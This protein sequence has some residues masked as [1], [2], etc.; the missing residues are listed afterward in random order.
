M[1]IK[2][3]LNNIFVI[4]LDKDIDRYYN[5]INQ[6]NKFT[7]SIT[8]IPAIY[9]KNLNNDLLNY[10]KKNLNSSSS[11]KNAVIG[12]ALSH[13]KTY[14]TIIN[15][16]LDYGFI[17]ED[18]VT[19][20]STFDNVL[21]TDLPDNWDILYIGHTKNEYPRNTCSRV[22]T[23]GYKNM[24]MYNKRWIIFDNEN[25]VPMGTWSYVVNKKA[26]MY[27]LNNYKLTE[28]IDVF[29]VKQQTLNDL[30]VYG[31][32]PSIVTHCYDFGSNID[33][34]FR[35]NW[36]IYIF[37]CS[38]IIL[39]VLLK[40][41][42]MILLLLIL[43]I[44]KYYNDKDNDNYMKLHFNVP[45]NFGQ[46]PFD[47]FGNVWSDESKNKLKNMLNRL[48]N[49]PYFLGYGTLLGWA[50]HDK[51]IIPWDDDMDI[52]LDE[53]YENDLL[54]HLSTYD[55]IIVTK[56]PKYYDYQCPILTNSIRWNYK[57]SLKNG[58]PIKNYEYTFP[59]IDIFLYKLHENDI[60]E[61]MFEDTIV[62]VPVDYE[63]LLNR[64]YGKDWKTK[65]VSSSWNH[66]LEK[67][68]E[69]SY[70]TSIDCDLL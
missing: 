7:S 41:Y 5:F 6:T 22:S 60:M 35:Y 11:N 42:I 10:Y 67:P 1:K 48:N 69:D 62:N 43:I 53:K 9:G 70:I 26:A 38:L 59:F 12:C 29:I 45:N 23:P 65:C 27:I 14:N 52:F 16:N 64:W 61:D 13:I 30:N 32:N 58:I 8:R 44:Y 20:N 2:D 39:S 34:I 25:E 31:F 3:L 28:P 40:R 47:P 33:P 51:K 17:F 4:N 15:T 55:D 19:F 68:I 56:G 18:D 46:D 49:F 57:I 37:L 54:Q 66:R 36:I 21:N 50:R 24:K 63:T